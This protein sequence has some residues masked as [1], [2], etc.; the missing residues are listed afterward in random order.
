MREWEKVGLF[1]VGALLTS[2]TGAPGQTAASGASDPTVPGS[3]VV[4]VSPIAA[5]TLPILCHDRDRP[6]LGF[7]TEMT[8]PEWTPR[9]ALGLSRPDDVPGQAVVVLELD[10]IRYSASFPAGES[11]EGFYTA[12]ASVVSSDSSPGR[13]I[14]FTASC[15]ERLARG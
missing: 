7:V 4:H 1:C 14:S 2:P 15:M 10:G 13:M 5:D 9:F 6:E 3:A 12:M 8:D 11:G